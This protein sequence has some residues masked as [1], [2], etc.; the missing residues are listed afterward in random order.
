MKSASGGGFPDRFYGQLI[1][2]ADAIDRDA[3]NPAGREDLSTDF[4]L[5]RHMV[6]QQAGY[7]AFFLVANL[8]VE[9]PGLRIEDAEVL[10]GP[11]AGDRALAMLLTV[12]VADHEASGFHNFPA[13]RDRRGRD[14]QLIS[15]GARID[16]AE[17]GDKRGQYRKLAA[18]SFERERAWLP[19][20]RRCPFRGL[21]RGWGEHGLHRIEESVDRVDSLLGRGQVPGAIDGLDLGAHALEKLLLVD[22]LRQKIAH[23]EL[24]PV[25]TGIHIVASG[26]QNHRQ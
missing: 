17:K 2:R 5:S 22:R 23:P 3:L 13:Q 18:D 6:D 16:R 4:H 26:Q 11:S 14:L 19:G 24:H 15:V 20:G 21:S 9:N 12:A 25:G 7:R 10:S 1:E 8:D